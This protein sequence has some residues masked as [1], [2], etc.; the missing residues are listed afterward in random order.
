M[1]KVFLVDDNSF[2]RKVMK[3]LI[4]LE[5]DFKVCGEADNAEDALVLVEQ[6]NPNIALVDI[7]LGGNEQGIELIK[8]IRQKGHHFPVLT[9]SL[10][11]ETLYADRVM[12]AG[13]QGY[14]M[15]QDAPETLVRAIR[16]VLEKESVF[17]TASLLEPLGRR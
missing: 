9:I 2:V 15:K 4:E 13:G 16:Y 10:H 6:L 5:K 17:F 1:V 12:N 14:L 3:Q 7:S 8:S 11:E